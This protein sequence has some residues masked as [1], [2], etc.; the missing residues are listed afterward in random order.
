MA[1]PKPAI[2]RSRIVRP[3]DAWWTVLLVDP[4][5][6]R[7]VPLLAGRR[8]ITP[9][10]ITWLAHLLGVASAVAFALDALLVGALLFEARFFADC[11]DGKL[12]R[13][14]GQT[15]VFGRELDVNGDLALVTINLAALGLGH[16][17]GG[18]HTVAVVALTS[19]FLLSMSLLETRR[20]LQAESGTAATVDR[21][22]KGR[23][24]RAFAQRRMLPIPS[25]VDVEHAL[26]FV[27]P[28]FAAFGL[29]FVAAAF[30]AGSVF[31]WLN[32]V[33]YGIGL[34]RASSSIDAAGP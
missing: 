9:D 17:E 26:L 4:F 25:S 1:R 18:G 5:A 24:G 2:D 32:C 23:V 19:G 12:A 15:S 22:M 7:V 10:R 30:L 16:L 13:S 3:I 29:D 11:L 21:L 8:W 31:Y 28:A 20:R 6:V 14:T 34:L 33:R 27:T